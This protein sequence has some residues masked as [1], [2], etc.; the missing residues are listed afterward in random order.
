MKLKKSLLNF[1]II[2]LVLSAGMVKP[3]SA[4]EKKLSASA[5]SVVKE[6]VAFN[7]MV[8]ARQK[9]D[10]SFI[11]PDGIRQLGSPSQ[12]VSYRSSNVNGK[13]ENVMEVS[14]TY[15][16]IAEK[17]G[18]IV[19][20]PAKMKAG[21]KEYLSN[22]VRIK[23]VENAP[24]ESEN[25][26]PP[27]IILQ[28]IPSRSSIYEGEQIVIS[29]KVMVRERMQITSFPSRSYE[30]FWVEELKGDDFAK[31]EVYEGYQYRSQVVTRDLI[32]AQKKGEMQ[33]GPYNM[34]V[35]VQKVV[36][37]RRRN[38]F[39]D[40]FFDR[41]F[42][43]YE[44]Q[45]EVIKS[46]T[47]K[48]NVKPLPTGAPAGY[49][50]A[51]GNFK[52]KAEIS[53]DSINVNE[54]ISIKLRISG[55][56]NLGLISNPDIDFPPD[57]DVLEPGKTSKLKHDENGTTG[58]VEF[59][60][61]VIPRHGGNY[62]ISPVDFSFF[63]P[64]TKKYDRY[65]SDDF[66]FYAKGG[67]V[68]E[69]SEGSLQTGFF[70]E[71]VRNL[72]SDILF[73]KLQSPKFYRKAQYLVYKAWIYLV[74]IIGIVGIIAAFFLKRKKLA[75]ES[76]I[77]YQRNKRA[78]KL[79]GR[80]LKNARELLKKDDKGIYEEILRAVNGYLSDRLALNTS[81]LSRESIASEL[82]RRQVP[83]DLITGLWELMDQCEMARY[84]PVDTVDK[85][86][87]YEK[88]VACLGNIEELM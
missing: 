73:I 75:R 85:K 1:F 76:D 42:Q 34:D 10:I 56:G 13:L 16:L 39:D 17:T 33:I 80:R 19:L 29:A 9:G 6:G 77:F 20:P 14:Y 48:I 21:R 52:V 53:A 54:A 32:T 38:V 88:A 35:N 45:A 5:P 81:D 69:N 84:S 31:N 44:N 79:A 47:L 18:E 57:L 87:L 11:P 2:I 70:R 24:A 86:T 7:Y 55:K 82:E 49:K 74:F 66:S 83:N 43:S 58:S 59:E 41:A 4:Q 15:A 36:Q 46:N 37:N 64:V 60:Y 28:M 3:V 72:D 40:P 68:S 78:W 51:V 50:G 62:R 67:E 61:V 25:G 26:E 12:M 8:M 65:I 27:G 30:G 63:N 22:E 23:V 71:D